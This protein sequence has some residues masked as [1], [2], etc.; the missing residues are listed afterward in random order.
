MLVDDHGVPVAG[1][2]CG[3]A[4]LAGKRQLRL[5]GL[6]EK[7]ARAA[8]VLDACAVEPEIQEGRFGSVGE[9]VVVVAVDVAHK[10]TVGTFAQQVDLGFL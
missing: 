5:A 7:S 10:R 3:L 4:Q 8:D 9:R 6:L 2:A 1:L